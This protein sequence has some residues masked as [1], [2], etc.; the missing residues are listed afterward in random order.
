MTKN[1]EKYLFKMFQEKY[2]DIPS[3]VVEFGDKPDV[4]V[5]LDNGQTIGI[6]LTECIYDEKLMSESE[7]QIKFNN[8][9]IA[10][11]KGLMPFRF[12]LDVDIDT[13]IPLKQN[14]IESTIQEIV[15][16]CI[17]EFSNLQP[18]ESS[19]LEQLDVDWN[20][21]PNYF[22]DHFYNQGY[23]KL[24]KGISRISMSRFD[25][26]TMS[27]HPESK[28][29]VV[30]DFKDEDLNHILSKKEKS[31]KNYKACTLQWLVIGEGGDFY[32][33]R[34]KIDIKKGFSTSFDKVFLYRRW[35]SEVIEL[36]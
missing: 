1:E 30:P 26:L 21:A 20:E 34:D 28:G 7:F 3:G 32:S 17:I 12:M 18:N 27:H 5:L 9:V 23:R 33:Y 24:P 10:K 22:Y 19:S 13:N 29:G 36:K 16:I 35:D 8:K 4:I 11:L 6:E 15:N 31:L 14:Q 25:V 2:E